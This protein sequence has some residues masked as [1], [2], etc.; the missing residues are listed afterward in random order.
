MSK[1][2]HV[3]RYSPEALAEIDRYR[4][5]ADMIEGGRAPRR[6]AGVMP[7]RAPH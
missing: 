3:G 4:E 1:A 5:L 6:D 7:D 2:A